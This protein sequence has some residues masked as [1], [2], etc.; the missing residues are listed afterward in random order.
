MT[1]IY[2]PHIKTHKDDLI[3]E[4]EELR[5]DK[6]KLEDQNREANEAQAG[7]ES[8][9]R[10]LQETSDW[11]NIILETIRQNGHDKEI[12]ARLRA[13]ESPQAIADWLIEQVQVQKS[14]KI[15]PP[16][17]GL[18]D[19]VYHFERDY[20]EA[21]GLFRAK[22]SRSTEPGIVWTKVSQSHTLVGHLFDLY[23]TW[24][25]PV[26][27]LFSELDFKHS[28]R[29]N[30]GKYCSP[31]LVNAICA[32]ACHLLENENA[33]SPRAES[34]QAATL[35]E[36]FLNSARAS[37]TPEVYREVTSVQALAIMYLVEVSSGKARSAMGYLRSA[38]EN[39]KNIK[40]NQ[41]AESME[42][43][44]WGINT[45]NTYGCPAISRQYVDGKLM[46]TEPVLG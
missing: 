22:R 16:R 24:V 4:I 27:M 15:E 11:L 12:V 28:F 17:Q 9:N 20:Q 23:F 30:E 8:R 33:G 42:I 34:P 21:D 31:A 46:S 36:G 40:E 25:H 44:K 37:L 38:V 18:L 26:H 2:E 32:M 14:I 13:G 41:S 29:S 45:L 19:V 7:L 43:T 10:D 1:C 6:S 39:M 35:R 5:G 3:K